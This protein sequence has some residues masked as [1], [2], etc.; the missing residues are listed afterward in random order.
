[1]NHVY[2]DSNVAGQSTNVQRQPQ[3]SDDL[4]GEN[5]FQRPQV[6]ILHSTEQH[7]LSPLDL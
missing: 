3:G 1:M 5:G 2:I 7:N 6:R 4:F